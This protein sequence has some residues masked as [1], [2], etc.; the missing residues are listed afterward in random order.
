MKK[1]LSV[2]TVLLLT[3]ITV[4]SSS[5]SF[6]KNSKVSELHDALDKLYPDTGIPTTVFNFDSERASQ[7]SLGLGYLYSGTREEFEDFQRIRDFSIRLSCE[8]SVFEIHVIEAIHASDAR[9]LAEA[10]SRRA[11]KLNETIAFEKASGRISCAS[12]ADVYVKGKY[13]F[14]LATPDNQAAI[15]AIEKIL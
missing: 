13:V 3:A 7:N 2:T 15:D 6:Q 9:I 8:I 10:M 5:C 11:S 14:L 1:L 12:G 4:I